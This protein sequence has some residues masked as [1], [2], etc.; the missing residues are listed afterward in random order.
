VP[1]EDAAS[2]T[3][4]TH[5]RYLRGSVCVGEILEDFAVLSAGKLLWPL[6]IL[7]T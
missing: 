7:R 3:Q 6:V 4:N 2:Y 1:L 5:T